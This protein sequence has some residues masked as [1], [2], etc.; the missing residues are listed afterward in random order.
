MTIDDRHTPALFAVDTGGRRTGGGLFDAARLTQARILSGLAKTELAEQIGVSAAAVGQYES[1]VNVPRDDV[2]ARIAK[3]LAMPV[4]YFSVGR[5]MARVD[6]ISA[7]FRSLRSTR[8]RDRNLALATAGQIWELTFALERHVRLPEPSLPSVEPGTPPALAAATLREH[9]GMTAGPIRHLTANMEAKGVVIAIRPI[10]AIDAVDAFSTVILDRPIVIT[11][12]RRSENVFR[13]RFSLAHE[14][15]HLL[16]H[17]DSDG[18]GQVLEREADQFAAEFLTPA[19]EMD[20]VLPM[21]LDL[22]VLDKIG[23]T[24]GVSVP[25][26]VRRM[27]ERRRVTESSARR[28]YQRLNAAK[29]DLA[30]PT[31]AYPGE[32]PTLLTQAAAIAADHGAGEG[33]LANSLRWPA[34]K[35][36]DLL[37]IEDSRPALTV[38][39]A[40]PVDR[41]GS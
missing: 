11:T 1:G 21:R 36:R 6:T 38:V 39:E 10:G 25:S 34:S 15:G 3:T 41:T 7:Q 28:A 13:H 18:Q 31:S 22:H 8:V 4:E 16:L 26:L 40:T 23:R 35:V 27:V 9:W 19:S 37:G 17:R 29:D 33:A 32:Q 14:M 5:P 2:L 20:K 24:W 12:P 30:D